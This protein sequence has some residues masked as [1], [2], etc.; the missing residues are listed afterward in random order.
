[1]DHKEK[2]ERQM[3]AEIEIALKIKFIQAIII[4]AFLLSGVAL[5]AVV[6]AFKVD[7]YLPTLAYGVALFLSWKKFLGRSNYMY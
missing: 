2:Y 4:A 7:G 5:F 1:M 6:A 3:R